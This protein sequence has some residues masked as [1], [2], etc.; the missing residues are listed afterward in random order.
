MQTIETPT[1]LFFA[2]ITHKSKRVAELV[3]DDPKALE[4]RA[5][6]YAANLNMHRAVVQVRPA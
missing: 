3:G 1:Q 6:R 5:H 4:E 2:V